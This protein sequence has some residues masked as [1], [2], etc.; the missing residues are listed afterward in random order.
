MAR[1]ASISGMSV[2]DLQREIGRRQR[3]VGAL[4]RRRAKLL[5]KVAALDSEIAR[6]GGSAGRRGGSMSGR[7]RARNSVSLVEAMAQTLKGK[8]MGVTELAAAVQKDGYVTTSPNFRTIV[9]QALI[10][11]KK[12]FKRVERGQY[13][14]A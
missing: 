12:Q 5:R 9:N 14:V 10:K 7:T 2:A 11:F 13:T 6:H 4:E 1:G 8:T 3:K